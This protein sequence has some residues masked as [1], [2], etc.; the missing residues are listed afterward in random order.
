METG[1]RTASPN[2]IPYIAQHLRPADLDEITAATRGT[3][4]P[5]LALLW[6]YLASERCWVG[7]LNG[8]PELI[9]GVGDNGMIWLMGTRNILSPAIAKQIVT[10][11]PR[12]LDVL[13]KK[14]PILHN[15]VHAKNRLHVK[16]LKLMGFK[17]I[18]RTHEGDAEF[19][20]F[21]R[22]QPCA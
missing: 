10:Q 15:K 12:W 1:V 3:M 19:L 9:W 20:Q 13:N 5:E 21:V 18:K 14:H 7:T 2:D 6:S 22:I 4:L 16:W 11:S 17:F 8:L